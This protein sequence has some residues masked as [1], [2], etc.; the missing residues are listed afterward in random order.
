LSGERPLVGFNCRYESDAQHPV[1]D[2]VGHYVPYHRALVAAGALPAMVPVLDDRATLSLYLDRLDGF[3][4][5][6]GR[7][8]PPLAYGQEP[9]PETEECD[10]RRF[11]CDRLLAQLVLE[12]PMPVLGICMG[13]QLLNVVYGGTLIQHLET[14]VRHTAIE[15]GNDSFHPVVL[16]EDNLLLEILRVAELEVNSSHHQA[17]DKPAPGLRVLARAPDGIVE[18]VEMTDRDFFLGVQWHPERIFERPEQRR[19][20]EAFVSACRMRS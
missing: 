1:R 18:A 20:I 6:G 17:V 9:H 11:A 7:D 12:R 5:T 16:E 19:L 2:Y 4:F 14:D 8:V 13:T 3:L 15:P 10:P